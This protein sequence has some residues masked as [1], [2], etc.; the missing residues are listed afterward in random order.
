MSRGVARFL[1]SLALEAK[2]ELAD[3][4]KGWQKAESAYINP[5]KVVALRQRGQAAAEERVL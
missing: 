5:V 2:V 4:V 3:V 1:V